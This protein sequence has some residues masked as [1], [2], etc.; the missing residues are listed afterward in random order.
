VPT[1]PGPWAHH[2]H[3]ADVS[4][5]TEMDFPMPSL[6]PPYVCPAALKPSS[7]WLVANMARS[8]VCASQELRRG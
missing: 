5:R 1:S 3:E 8:G 2:A 7:R 4:A 6:R